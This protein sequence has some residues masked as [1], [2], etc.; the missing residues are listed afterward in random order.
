M[1]HLR[2]RG[3]WWRPGTSSAG[4]VAVADINGDTKPDLVA[5]SY[6]S[7]SALVAL[8][9]GDGTFEAPIYFGL[10]DSSFLRGTDLD[11][12]GKA[13]LAVFVPYRKSTFFLQRGTGVMGAQQ[14]GVI[15]P[16]MPNSAISTG[17]GVLIL[18]SRLCA[19]RSTGRTTTS[20]RTIWFLAG[21]GGGLFG[22][23]VKVATQS[24]PISAGTGLPL[25]ATADFTGASKLGFVFANNATRTLQIFSGNGDGSFAPVAQTSPVA[26][27]ALISADFDGDGIDDVAVAAS[28]TGQ[29]PGT[30]TVLFGGRGGKYPDPKSF[31][32]CSAPRVL[33]KGDFNG[34]SKPDLA[35]ICGSQITLLINAG[36]GDFRA[37]LAVTP[38][39]GLTAA[40]VADFD[41]DGNDDLAVSYGLN[42]A[43]GG[44]A[45]LRGKSDGTFQTA[46]GLD[47][48]ADPIA[49][50]AQKWDDDGKPDLAVLSGLDATVRRS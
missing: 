40:S 44:G 9:R 15:I 10:T 2:A 25:L 48:P 20:S 34:D 14:A 7:S 22:Q 36:G 13:D 21:R 50:L 49:L 32:T 19:R 28:G 39:S 4:A 5:T 47:L 46:V 38:V 43:W 26:A 42:S 16:S 35:A 29:N 33:L 27:N 12:D 11:G 18:S 24:Y 8:G 3:W 45:I 41:G 30:V 31:P 17:M 6:S 23:P 37:A 1:G